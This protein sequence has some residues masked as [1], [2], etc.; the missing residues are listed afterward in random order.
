MVGP[1]C[2]GCTGRRNLLKKAGGFGV[3][4]VSRIMY[5]G[6]CILIYIYIYTHIYVYI[7]RDRSYIVSVW[8]MCGPTCFCLALIGHV[9]SSLQRQHTN[10]T[11][12]VFL[13]TC[14]SQ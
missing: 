12:V 2:T 7:E 1:G 4:V 10:L 6:S 13:A 8:I 11:L 5:L 14:S 9:L 3:E